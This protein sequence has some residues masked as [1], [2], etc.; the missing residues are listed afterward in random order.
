MVAKYRGA[1]WDAV[2]ALM[3]DYHYQIMWLRYYLP[4]SR[5]YS[6]DGENLQ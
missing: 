4:K 3:P 2:A 5:R 6:Y 1:S